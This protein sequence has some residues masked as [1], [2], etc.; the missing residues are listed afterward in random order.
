MSDAESELFGNEKLNV[1]RSD[2]PA[3]THVD[4]SALVQTVH[5]KTN[6]RHHGLPSAFKEQTG[7][8][9]LV[10]TSFNVRGKPIV[11]IPDDA[12]RCFMKCKMET[13]FVGNCIL[14]EGDQN[15]ASAIDYKAKFALD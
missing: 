2:I 4:C 1:L 6:R 5:N 3:I 13:R 10:N 9:V 11:N 15:P 8:S 7:C 14:R 12:F